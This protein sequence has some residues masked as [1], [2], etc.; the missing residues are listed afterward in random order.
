V[1][2]VLGTSLLLALFLGCG[3]EQQNPAIAHDIATLGSRVDPS[4]EA[5]TV[6]AGLERGGWTIGEELSGDGYVAFDAVREDDG[7]TA[8]RVITGRGIAAALEVPLTEAAQAISLRRVEGI[9]DLIVARLDPTHERTCLVLLRVQEDGRVTQVPLEL[10]RFGE[11]ACV[12]DVVDADGDGAPEL[13][14]RVRL[15][16]LSRGETPTVA[17]LLAERPPGYSPAPPSAYGGFWESEE[18]RVRGALEEARRRLDVEA[19]YRRAVELAALAR[20][21]GASTNRQVT[22]FDEA[23][24]GLVLTEAQARGVAAARAHIANGWPEDVDSRPSED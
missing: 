6:A 11:E 5:R 23:L 12:E 15:Y 4:R 9:E 18:A 10:G 21:R 13:M 2:R 19:T 24:S 20:E 17:A 14:T 16:G 1:A 7:R 3:G 8:V 22:A